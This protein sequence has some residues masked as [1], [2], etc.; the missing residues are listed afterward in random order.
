MTALSARWVWGLLGGTLA[1]ATAGTAGCAS[2]DDS[3]LFRPGEDSGRGEDAGGTGA[4]NPPSPEAAAAADGVVLVHAAEFPSFRLCFEHLP[5]LAPQ[6]DSV[7]MPQANVVG[8]EIGSVV[9][10]D[11]L[12]VPGKIYVIPEARVRSTVGSEGG[13]TCGERIC[14][15]NDTRQTCLRPNLDYQEA[16]ELLEPVG[17]SGVELLSIAGC[18]GQGYLTPLGVDP[19]GCG[20]GWDPVAGNLASR[21]LRLVP[22]SS[23]GALPVQL[24]H[25]SSALEAYAGE[26][27]ID[28][29]FGPLASEAPLAQPVASSP[30]LF[31][32]SEPTSL[33][34]EASDDA[35]YA[36][37]GFRIT[38]TGGGRPPLAIDQ[39]LAAVQELSAPRAL[40]NEYY[41]AASS[42]V[43]VLLGDPRFAREDGDA[44]P[45]YDPRRAVHLLAVPVI[46]P[47]RDAGAP[48]D[49]SEPLDGGGSG[50]SP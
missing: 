21:V 14:E 4:F 10:I 17:S 20:E 24:V 39:S 32:A 48:P 16:G 1:L 9:R 19:A 30:P 49:G 50:G 40:P 31:E 43:L 44:G 26:G 18:G 36:S 23:D 13:A 35:V 37:H 45:T 41:R 25:M 27:T 42:Y 11:P 6:P 15:P 29:T 3:T 38:T 28:V 7:A 2:M 33:S 34:L 46:D 8:V 5:E 22:T 12:A 47:D